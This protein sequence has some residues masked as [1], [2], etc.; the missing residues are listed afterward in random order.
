MKVLLTA[1]YLLPHI[2]GIEVLVDR[3][4]RLLAKA[5]HEVIV[6]VSDG[7]DGEQ[8][9]YPDGVR[10]CRVPAW[11]GLE[12]FEVP[13]PIFSPSLVPLL[14]R[15]VRWCD[16]VHAHGLLY[17]NSFLTLCFA[18]AQG[19][20]T[21]LTEHIGLNWYPLGLRR[22]LQRAAMET[23][24]RTSARLACRCISFH[25]PILAL[26]R[27][28]AGPRGRIL[29][30]PNPLNQDL[31]HP[32]SANERYKA[33]KELGWDDGRPKVL[34][35][36]R[37]IPRKGVDLLLAARDPCF[38]LVFCGRKDSSVLERGRENGIYYL[39]PRSQRGLVQLYHAADVLALPSRSEA[40]LP[41]VVQEALACGLPVLL[42]EFHGLARYRHCAGLHLTAVTPDAVRRTLLE[43]LQ[44]R[45]VPVTGASGEVP[46]IRFLMDEET[47][48]REL[49]G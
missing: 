21:L 23:L 32:P 42:G 48:L 3:E 34:F 38:D 17:L 18:R 8:P 39:P 46:L 20:P 24:G 33:R 37:L 47:W 10:V 31:F 14:W 27:R 25:E 26:L 45:Q 9:R 19:K 12:R 22:L 4:A 7:G 36:G 15:V 6:L 2:G 44:R 30:L 41:L 16:I 40:G 28:L 29:D 13:W 35:V 1:H 11:N 43:I 49:Y 5:G